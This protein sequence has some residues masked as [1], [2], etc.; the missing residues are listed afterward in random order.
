MYIASLLLLLLPSSSLTTIE[1]RRSALQQQHNLDQE[2]CTHV[3]N[4]DIEKTKQHLQRGAVP[5]I[6]C[7][8][9]QKDPYY[10][11]YDP[12]YSRQ[13]T[14][15][16]YAT[17]A[18]SLNLLSILLID[19][20]PNV[21]IPRDTLGMTPLHYIVDPYIT[22]MH[23]H[24]CVLRGHL[25]NCTTLS[26]SK[27]MDVLAIA[28][29]DDGEVDEVDEEGNTITSKQVSYRSFVLKYSVL[30]HPI[31]DLLLK[32]YTNSKT[33]WTIGD[34]YGQTI[35]HRASEGGVL[36]IVRKIYQHAKSLLNQLDSNGETPLDR[37]FQRQHMQVVYWLRDQGGIHGTDKEELIVP[38]LVALE[39]ESVHLKYYHRLQNVWSREKLILLN[40]FEVRPSSI[41]Y[42]DIY[43]GTHEIEMNFTT[44]MSTMNSGY[45]FIK[46]TEDSKLW[47]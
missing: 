41:P 4:N 1:Q 5:N 45:L 22:M 16:F 40:N 33:E 17:H 29:M 23:V 34:H 15:I 6:K 28:L 19:D 26:S 20:H 32:S 18:L 25:T 47:R 2:L 11:N 38:R 43:G 36:S 9:Q 21:G 44:Y 31:I 39:S 13:C 12:Y 8:N 14:A 30:A 3:W 24:K 7:N 37:A 46:L 35:L 42:P 27:A 10:S